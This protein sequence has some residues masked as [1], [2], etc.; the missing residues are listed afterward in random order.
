VRVRGRRLVRV[1]ITDKQPGR[2][3]LRHHR[4]VLTCA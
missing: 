1:H 3:G 4:A 2:P